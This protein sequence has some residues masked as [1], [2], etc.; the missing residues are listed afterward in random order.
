M[1]LSA[2]ICNY[3]EKQNEQNENLA[4]DFHLASKHSKRFLLANMYRSRNVANN[5]NHMAIINFAEKSY[6]LA[7]KHLLSKHSEKSDLNVLLDNR[8]SKLVKSMK[9]KLTSDDLAEL[10]WASCGKNKLGLRTIPSAGALYPLELYVF[11]IDT[12]IGEGIFHYRPSKQGLECISNSLPDLEQYMVTTKGLEN[13]SAIFVTTAVFNRTV[14]K[15]DIRG[16][17][18]VLIEAGALSQNLSLKATELNYIATCLGG[19]SDV[20]IENMLGINGIDESVVN[21]IAITKKLM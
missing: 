15:Y 14:F 7:E 5:P 10:C 19:T 4:I 16:Y 11:S 8:T 21:G 18:Y 13:T 1:N 12:E 2:L 6:P 17:R 20:D 9:H 3:L